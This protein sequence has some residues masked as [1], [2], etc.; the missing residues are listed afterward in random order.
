VVSG[1]LP[2]EPIANT[3]IVDGGGNVDLGASYG[4]V[5]VQGLS[6]DEATDA[7]ARHLRSSLQNPQVSVV[8]VQPAG[9]QIIG[10]EHQ[11]APDGTINLGIYGT[12]FVAGMTVD[13]ARCSIESHLAEYFDEPAVSVEVFSYASKFYYVITEGPGDGVAQ[14]PV[15]G[16]E[17]VL[18]AIAIIGGIGQGSSKRIWISRPA[19]MG[20]G[21]D[22][23]LPVDWEAITKGADTCT[24]YQILPGDR[25]FVAADRFVL[26][27]NFVATLINPVERI[28]GFGLL[29][30]QTIQSLQRFPGG[31]F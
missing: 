21:C 27:E 26:I 4:V 18:D 5:R 19:P 13:E 15:T 16:N 24:N 2:E 29:G 28:F 25:V 23:V 22:Q 17:T 1:S 8:L 9:Q 3:F 7:I 14:V 12:V 10:G 30:A 31:T 6:L 11:V 20:M